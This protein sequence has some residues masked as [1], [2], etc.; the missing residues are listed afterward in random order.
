MFDLH[1][2][3]I[4]VYVLVQKLFI[5]SDVI[6]AENRG[7]VFFCEGCLE[8]CGGC[9]EVFLFSMKCKMF[10]PFPQA[11]P[12]CQYNTPLP[13]S[14]PSICLLQFGEEQIKF[15]RCQPL[16]GVNLS[17]EFVNVYFHYASS[18]LLYFRWW[19]RHFEFQPAHVAMEGRS[20]VCEIP[21]VRLQ[22]SLLTIFLSLLHEASQCAFGN[23]MCRLLVQQFFNIFAWFK[24]TTKSR[25]NY[26]S[27]YPFS[28]MAI[29]PQIMGI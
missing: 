9:L 13:P 21:H 8:V 22:I 12:S 26:V 25:E 4:M 29:S 15:Q 10:L 14:T 24:T 11:C 5:L 3:N 23:G 19:Q 18:G 2:E 16:L 27:L 28:N 1:K 7:S 17:P 20:N 6:I